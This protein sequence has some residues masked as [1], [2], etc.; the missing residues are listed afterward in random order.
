M[1][2]IGDLSHPG[3]A[4]QLNI[5]GLEDDIRQTVQE[6]VSRFFFNNPH[7]GFALRIRGE[8]VKGFLT[9]DHSTSLEQR[10]PQVEDFIR[11]L[12]ARYSKARLTMFVSLMHE[13][14][15][16][17]TP[18]CSN[19]YAMDAVQAA[20]LT[21]LSWAAKAADNQEDA[22]LQQ[23][24]RKVNLVSSP[25]LR[26]LYKK[27][28]AERVQN[29]PS[30]GFVNNLPEGFVR[31]AK[32]KADASFVIIPYEPPPAS[33]IAKQVP[34]VN[35]S[36]LPSGE[37]AILNSINLNNLPSSSFLER[38][39]GQNWAQ[40]A[41]VNGFV[42]L[43]ITGKHLVVK[44]DYSGMSKL[45]AA[46][47]EPSNFVL[48]IFQA[49]APLIDDVTTSSD[50]VLGVEGD[51]LVLFLPKETQRENL[52]LG[53]LI[54]EIN[55]IFAKNVLN[56][57][58]VNK[59]EGVIGEHE[60][61]LKTVVVETEQPTTLRFYKGGVMSSENTDLNKHEDHAEKLAK[62]GG[63]GAVVVSN[64]PLPQLDPTNEVKVVSTEP[65][66]Y[67][68]LIPIPTLLERMIVKSLSNT[69][70]LAN[71]LQRLDTESMRRHLNDKHLN[72]SDR[73]ETLSSQAIAA[74]KILYIFQCFK[75]DPNMLQF[76]FTSMKNVFSHQTI[77]YL[78]KLWEC[79]KTDHFDL[80]IENLDEIEI[81]YKLFLD[82]LSFAH[83]G[84]HQEA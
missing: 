20:G 17:I 48:D 26:A 52:Q 80:P 24:L 18:M 55:E 71:T 53:K 31:K 65:G 5:Q 50:Y 47:Q 6:E 4:F 81:A 8:T 7:S 51:A 82:L 56:I 3:Y 58:R 32:G 34:L 10:L 29:H 79:A 41:E 64:I 73:L 72:V 28:P 27:L 76:I 38:H 66:V 61:G 70:V 35:Y 84:G 59:L 39:A 44:L 13:L 11:S 75:D 49:I 69:P 19:H 42:E 1:V 37:L 54:R 43:Q 22:E 68:N 57:A 60:I 14:E 25:T 36:S 15:V 77:D 23:K 67:L 78:Q 46:G 33:P 21:H 9:T 62:K 30:A 40:H 74:G 63:N 2:E 12:E 83:E 45:V 16:S